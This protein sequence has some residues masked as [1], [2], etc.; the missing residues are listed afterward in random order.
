MTA[1]T[2]LGVGTL[3]M[4]GAGSEYN[5]F[6]RIFTTKAEAV[7]ALAANTWIPEG[8]K[9]NTCLTGDQG[10]FTYNF[11]TSSE[12]GAKYIMDYLIKGNSEKNS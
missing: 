9:T 7:A 3:S 2:T 4:R 11:G 12:S 5:L 8:G 10:F 6:S 1:L